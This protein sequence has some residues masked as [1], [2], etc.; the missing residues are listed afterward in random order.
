MKNSIKAQK[1]QPK[2]SDFDRNKDSPAL[3]PRDNLTLIKK[4]LVSHVKRFTFISDIRRAICKKDY[5]V[6]VM[7]I[8]P[9]C[10]F[11]TGS[12]LF[13]PRFHGETPWHSSLRLAGLEIYLEMLFQMFSVPLLL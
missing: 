9:R 13:H 10:V 6:N 3:Q 7:F 12:S 8:T 11:M 1:G 5:M 2:Q 4:L